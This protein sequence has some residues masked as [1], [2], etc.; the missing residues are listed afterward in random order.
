MNK[1]FSDPR[2]VTHNVLCLMYSSQRVQETCS[3]WQSKQ[4]ELL[5]ARPF[6]VFIATTLSI[7]KVCTFLCVV[8]LRRVR[9]ST[10]VKAPCRLH[11]KW[12][13]DVEMNIIT[14]HWCDVPD[15]DLTPDRVTNVAQYRGGQLSLLHFR[16]SLSVLLD[17]CTAMCML[18]LSRLIDYS[19][20][21]FMHDEM[22]CLIVA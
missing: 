3:K 9:K 4:K 5:S 1:L 19:P 12:S 17:E 18:G 22:Y 8:C 14:S 6:I 11:R 7:S 13:F 2:Y 20:R 16:A 15:V 10:S 21:R